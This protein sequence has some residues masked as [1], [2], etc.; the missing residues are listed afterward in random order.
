MR[1]I[2]RIDEETKTVAL[3]LLEVLAL[4]G[5]DDGG[6]GPQV[7]RHLVAAGKHAAADEAAEKARTDDEAEA[8]GCQPSLA[9]EQGLEH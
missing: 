9:L 4:D 2:S 8:D 7:L 6:V 5:R 3:H 1:S